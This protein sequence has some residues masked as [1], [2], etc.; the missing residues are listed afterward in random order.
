MDLRNKT[1]LITG[2]GSGIGEAI[3]TKFAGAGARIIIVD[4]SDEAKVVTT[5]LEG[6][7]IHADLSEVDDTARAAQEVIARFGRVDVLVNNAGIQHVAPVE[8]FPI[9]RFQTIIQLMLVSP[10]VLTKYL[11]PPMKTQGW[12]RIINMSSIHGLVASPNKSAYTAA[13]HGLIGLTKTTALEV[14]SYGVTANAICPSFVSTPLVHNQLGD[15]A[16]SMGIPE[17]EVL[18]QILLQQA[19]IKR[20]IEPEEVANLA[21]FLASDLA[22][23]ITGSAYT[24]D[25]GW[26]AR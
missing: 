20:M 8:D 18:D 15:L 1:A 6:T 26:T 4:I 9:D 24:I 14:G 3:A 2:G 5:R 23:A 11:L 22:S 10:F 25:G 12:G 13:K 7:Y 21:L 17:E 19:S 16:L